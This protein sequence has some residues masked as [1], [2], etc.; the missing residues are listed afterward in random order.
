MVHHKHSKTT[1]LVRAISQAQAIG[2]VVKGNYD[3]HVAGQEDLV[4]MMAA[5]VLVETAGGEA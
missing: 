4:A 1:H 5:G 2:H 3:C